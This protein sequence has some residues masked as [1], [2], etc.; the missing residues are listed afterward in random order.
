[1]SSIFSTFEIIQD[2]RFI[3]RFAIT[4]LVTYYPYIRLQFD[5][6]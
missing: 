1:M 2:V 6:K 4:L 3:I 5:Q